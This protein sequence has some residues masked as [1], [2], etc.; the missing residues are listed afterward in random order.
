MNGCRAEERAR[1]PDDLRT[2]LVEALRAGDRRRE[3]RQVLELGHP[4]TCLVEQR[5]VLDRAGDERRTGN[6]ELDFGVG[7]LPRS[8][9]VEGDRADRVAALAEERDGD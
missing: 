6:E 9:G 8:L 5:R 2:E 3:L 7:E 4:R 1:T